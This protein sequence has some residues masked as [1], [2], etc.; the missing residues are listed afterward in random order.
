MLLDADYTARLADFGFA[1]LVGNIPEALAYLQRSTAHPGA[2]RWIAPEQIDPEATFSRETKSD[3]YSFG[4]VGL[5][6][7][8]QLDTQVGSV[9]IFLQVLS[10]KQPWSE[11]RQDMAI[12]LHLAKGHKPG[13]PESPTLNDSHWN[14]IQDCWSPM[15]ERPTTEV[16]ISTIQQFLSHCPLS[17]PLSDLLRSWSGRAD[18]GTESSSYLSQVPTEGSSTHVTAQAAS[19]EGDQNR[20]RVT[21]ISVQSMILTP[22]HLHL[23]GLLCFLMHLIWTGPTKASNTT[24]R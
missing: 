23:S 12:V 2:L 5:Q 3:I 14:L 15:E 17:P 24:H 16:I 4:C 1:S 8:V 20:Y 9:L 7:R 22:R 18:R 21:L 11:I 13:R 6:V 10:G 19:D